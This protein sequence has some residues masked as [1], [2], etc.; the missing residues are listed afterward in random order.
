MGTYKLS[1][2]AKEDLRR[3]YRRGLRE[4]GEAQADRHYNAFFDQFEQIVEHPLLYQAVD[5]IRQGYRRCVCG[6]DSI[7]YRI[8]VETVEIMAMLSSAAKTSRTGCRRYPSQRLAEQSYAGA[9]VKNP[10][11]LNSVHGFINNILCSRE[12]AGTQNSFGFFQSVIGV[13]PIDQWV[14]RGSP[15]FMNNSG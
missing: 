11:P 13:A 10:V 2:N 15:F 8:E 4:Y 12:L 9:G 3:I 5:D 1:E 14:E 7:Y 6:V